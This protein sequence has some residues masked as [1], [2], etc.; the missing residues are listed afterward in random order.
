M[1]RLLG[2]FL[3]LAFLY[4]I[5]ASVVDLDESNFDTIVDGSKDVLVEFF[6]PWCG[7]C[8][9]LAPIYDQLGDA[10]KNSKN[11]VIAK[12]DADQH[13]SLGSRFGVTGF[14]TIKFFPKGKKS[15]PK[16]YNSGRDLESFA[17]FLYEETGERAKISTP[18]ESVVALTPST[19]DSIVNDAEKAV[20]VEF[21]APWC[22]HCKTLAPKYEKVA[23]TFKR[24]KDVV[25]A[26]VDADQ[27]KELS[28]R[29]GVS[30][31]PTIKFF[32]KG[33]KKS[34]ED[35]NGGRDEKDFI[36]FIN[37]KVGSRRVLGGNLDGQ[38]GRIAE[39]DSIVK[40]FDGSDA[41]LEEA[42]KKAASSNSEWA[43][44]YIKVLEKLKDKPT[45]VD[46][47]IAR[48]EKV[49]SGSIHEDKID[50]FTI[51]INILKSFQK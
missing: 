25:I 16:P 12:V 5:G 42:K 22:G 8:K 32:P 6:A 17:S 15:D 21:Y 1:N 18:K 20:L 37:E 51:R 28:S 4:C 35:Y 41:Q 40:S 44:F 48:L 47:E 33:S 7:H 14:P 9:N 36:S 13:R 34:G 46:E 38:A 30:G 2:V 50:Q 39:L 23:E 29:F 19:F 45:Y 27:H 11:V 31:F 43:S 24:Q 49:L 10:Y 26:K 3:G